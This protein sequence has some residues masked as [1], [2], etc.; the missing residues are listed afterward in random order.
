MRSGTRGTR[1]WPQVQGT[2]AG[3][4][5]GTGPRWHLGNVCKGLE[6]RQVGDQA[7]VW[8]S[9]SEVEKG[10]PRYVLELLLTL[11]DGSEVWVKGKSVSEV[12]NVTSRRGSRPVPAQG[13]ASGVGVR[14]WTAI[15]MVLQRH[16]GK[17]EVVVS[18]SG[19]GKPRW[20]RLQKIENKRQAN[21]C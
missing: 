15:P 1:A 12:C 21:K 4:A 5:L 9:A 16:F 2:M 7:W 8:A 18:R 10:E 19:A 3:P 11:T 6:R 20:H 13:Q 17:A 14:G